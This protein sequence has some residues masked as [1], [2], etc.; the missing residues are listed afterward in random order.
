MALYY[1][2]ASAANKPAE[3]RSFLSFDSSVL[4]R[5]GRF[6]GIVVLG[7]IVLLHPELGPRHTDVGWV[8]MLAVAPLSSIVDFWTPREHRLVSQTLFDLSGLV[9]FCALLPAIWVPAMICGAFL[10]GSSVPRFARSHKVAFVLL[11]SLF[12]GLMGL[13]AEHFQVAGAWL[14][15]LAFSVA[16]PFCLLYA[17]REQHKE[18][19]L[20]DRENLMDSLTQMAGG[21]GHDF[22]NLLT[23]IQGNAELAELKLDRNHVARPY[24]QAL[25]SES[26]KAQL[27]SAQ[28]LAFSGGV[29]TGRERLDVRAELMRLAGLLESALP[30]DV[31]LRVRAEKSLP[32]VSA[33]RAELQELAVGC[34]L[35]VAGAID[36]APSE[37]TVKLRRVTRRHGDEL[38]VQVRA[39]TK[40]SGSG[41][42]A[43]MPVIRENLAS[44]RFDLARAQAIMKDHN[45]AIAVHGNRR[46]KRVITLRL[47]GLADAQ[48][49]PIRNVAPDPTVPRHL[50][51][52]ESVPEVHAVVCEMLSELGHRVTSAKDRDELFAA[53]S[54]DS[55]IDAVMLSNSNPNCEALLKR[56]HSVR[57]G[58]PALL[59]ESVRDG[60]VLGIQQANVNYLAKPYSSAGLNSAIKR[61]FDPLRS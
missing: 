58:L 5:L 45:G 1:P 37:V 15:L 44:L 4:F 9:V 13:L 46:E 20:R 59:P 23:G 50:L 57:P 29:A 24:L 12:L 53:I 3:Q 26:Q 32:L 48:S 19:S 28:L 39:N 40:H 17:L 60:D 31:R 54:Q 56:I 27:F 6:L 10:I 25:L 18:K 30:R 47:P 16:T 2:L 41:Q 38:V 51:L 22:N 21:I 8:L 11:P 33:N 55:T 42:T 7:A 43:R 36:L 35:H 34:I 49:A 52:L 61:L 14:S